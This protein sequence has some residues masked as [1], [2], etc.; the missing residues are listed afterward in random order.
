[1]SVNIDTS[2]QDSNHKLKNLLL[3]FSIKVDFIKILSSKCESKKEIFIIPVLPDD[4]VRLFPLKRCNKDHGLRLKHAPQSKHGRYLVGKL[5]IKLG[6]E[7][8]FATLRFSLLFLKIVKIISH[9]P[10]EVL[11]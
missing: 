11:E 3:C 2:T 6:L 4:S 9:P 1:M 5:F 8:A 7:F 10:V